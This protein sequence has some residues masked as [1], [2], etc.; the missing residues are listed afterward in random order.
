MCVGVGVFIFDRVRTCIHA[1]IIMF[2][3]FHDLFMFSSLV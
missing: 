1:Y 2:T 3:C